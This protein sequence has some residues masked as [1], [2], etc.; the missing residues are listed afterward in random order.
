MQDTSPKVKRLLAE[1][2]RALAPEERV[3]MCTEM[4][5]WARLLVEASLPRGLDEHARR[6]L[7]CKRFYGALAERAFPD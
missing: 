3:R 4:F 7:V 6:K 2:Y 1:R 5:D